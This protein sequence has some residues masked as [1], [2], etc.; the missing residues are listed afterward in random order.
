MTF[1]PGQTLETVSVPTL[2]DAIAE[3]T[4]QFIAVLSDASTGI[5]IGDDTATVDIEDSTNVM[6][7][8]EPTSFSAQE[9]S[10]EA[11]FI[12]VKRTSTTRTVTVLFSTTD[13]TAT[14]N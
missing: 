1:N 6:V 4:E 8:F 3:N 14:G 11:T 2:S 7:E 10:R 5:T 12:I 9:S 13:G